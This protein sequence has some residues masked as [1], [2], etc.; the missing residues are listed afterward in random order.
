VVTY[1]CFTCSFRPWLDAGDA[2][3]ATVTI[4]TSKGKTMTVPAFQRDGR[5]VTTY[6]LDAGQAA[7]VARGAVVDAWGNF[8]GTGT[9]RVGDAP[10]TTVPLKPLKPPKKPR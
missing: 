1:F 7:F 4:V 6:Q 10:G 8:N 5:W 3:Q 2:S 9:A